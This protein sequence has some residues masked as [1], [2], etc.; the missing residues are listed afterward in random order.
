[1]A[2]IGCVFPVLLLRTNLP[3]PHSS[4]LPIPPPTRPPPADVQEVWSLFDFLMPGLLGSERQFNARYGRML[5]VG[6]VQGGLGLGG[7]RRSGR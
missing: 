4:L 1:M 2:T 6:R 3:L 5:Q 7:L